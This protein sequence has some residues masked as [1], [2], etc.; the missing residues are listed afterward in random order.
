MP[1]SKTKRRSKSKHAACSLPHLARQARGSTPVAYVLDY[2]RKKIR[3]PFISPLAAQFEFCTERPTQVEV[4]SRDRVEV[5]AAIEEELENHHLYL[6]NFLTHP[7][8]GDER[9][10]G[11]SR[12]DTLRPFAL[13]ETVPGV[14]QFRVQGIAVGRT[15]M[16]RLLRGPN[17]DGPRA[18]DLP[19]PP[20]GHHRI[21]LVM[22]ANPNAAGVDDTEWYD[23]KPSR[24][25]RHHPKLRLRD[26]IP[27]LFRR[28]DRDDVLSPHYEKLYADGVVRIAFLFGFDEGSHLTSQDARAIWQILT[29]PPS[30]RFT[31]RT[32]GDY[33][34]HGPGLG[35][36]DPTGGDFDR[37]NLDGTTVLRR[38]SMNGM[39]P[40]VVRYR[41]SSP[42]KAGG[43][44]APE[45]SITVGDRPAPLGDVIPAGTLIERAL[46]VEIRLY[47]FDKSSDGRSP[48]DLIRQFVSVFGDND[49]IHYDGHANYG[50]GF[51]VGDQ[52]DDIL[53]A[54]DIGAYRRYFSPAYQIFSIG[55]CH[56]AGYF[57]DLFY[58]ELKPRKSPRNLDIVAAVNE[59]AF[60]DAVQQGLELVSAVLQLKGKASG[61]PRDWA[62]ILLAQSRPASFQAYL[63]VFGHPRAKGALLHG[64]GK[65]NTASA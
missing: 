56:G 18:P 26:P 58:N 61:E 49:L 2:F 23:F 51:F 30:R 25:R 53:W 14:Y 12:G 24:F 50:G 45:G 17:L 65:A 16:Y 59:A 34:Y 47:N 6:S 35:F 11:F 42:L 44:R 9:Q 40:A 55:A 7:L 43:V 33:G 29:A 52:P 37:L 31:R 27:I 41:L 21:F 13:R 38:D 8:Y 28:R 54:V 39:G 57:A 60:D 20:A 63:G 3:A 32:N 10:I 15:D 4:P 48:D 1:R 22:P 19:R 5:L 36:S 62:S 64:V 46:A